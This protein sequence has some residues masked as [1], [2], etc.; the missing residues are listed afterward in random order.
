METRVAAFDNPFDPSVTLNPCE[1]GRHASQ[2]DHEAAS[3]PQHLHS[4]ALAG[5]EAS[6]DTWFDGNQATEAASNRVIEQAVVRAL[7]PDDEVRRRFLQAVGMRTAMGAIASVLPIGAMQAIAQD[8][9]LAIEKKNLQ[10][11]FVAITCATPL[12][13]AH[14]LRFYEREGLNVELQR[15]A[16]WAL[17]RDKMINREYDASHM[18]SPMPLSISMG[19]GSVATGIN[20]ATIQ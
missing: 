7:F 12:I 16:G 13:M 6:P 10:V 4:A 9:K 1:C 8:N 19:L 2:A 17:V 15:T 3:A 11:G 18:L 5:G 14:P 20:V